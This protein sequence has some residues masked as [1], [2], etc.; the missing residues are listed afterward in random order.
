MQNTS[1]L[2]LTAVIAVA[3][4]L[5]VSISMGVGATLLYCIFVVWLQST[6]NK[7]FV[8][9]SFAPMGWARFKRASAKHPA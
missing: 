5:Q 7:A 3:D 2:L 8:G 4:G 6:V 9:G 1:R